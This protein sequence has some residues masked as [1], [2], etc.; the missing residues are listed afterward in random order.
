M[1]APIM[2]QVPVK[3]LPKAGLGLKFLR[4]KAAAIDVQVLQN[5]IPEDQ[6]KKRSRPKIRLRL[7]RTAK[8]RPTAPMIS[9]SGQ[10]DG[11]DR[12]QEI[13]GQVILGNGPGEGLGV[14]QFDRP[15]IEEDQGQAPADYPGRPPRKN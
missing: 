3:S 14:H 11:Q 15:G 1:A 2:D 6:I 9:N 7:P 8:I 13:R 4:G 12:Q 10:P 5:P